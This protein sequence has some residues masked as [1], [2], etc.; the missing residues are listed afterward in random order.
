MA[1]G[2]GIGPRSRKNGPFIK[3][4]S[5]SSARH[6]LRN[7]GSPWLESQVS[8][9]GTRI[10]PFCY[11]PT[12]RLAKWCRELSVYLHVYYSHT[13]STALWRFPQPFL[14]TCSGGSLRWE[15][16]LR[17]NFPDRT[18][19][20]SRKWQPARAAF[21]TLTPVSILLSNHALSIP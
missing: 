10:G 19:K 15:R 17:K 18:A 14:L 7:G 5:S 11:C 16:N 9:P 12:A 6:T 1:E 13:S 2:G 21:S 8:C 20:D 3:R 4:S